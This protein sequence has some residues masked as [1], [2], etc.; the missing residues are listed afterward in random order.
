[1]R[2]LADFV[3]ARRASG[4]T[5][6]GNEL[7]YRGS[8]LSAHRL[9]AACPICAGQMPGTAGHLFFD[10]RGRRRGLVHP[11]CFDEFVEEGEF[12]L[13]AGPDDLLV[14]ELAGPGMID[15]DVGLQLHRFDANDRLVDSAWVSD[16]G[17]FRPL[18]EG[19]TGR[20]WRAAMR[21]WILVTGVILP[22][23]ELSS[24]PAR[25]AFATRR[26]TVL[27]ELVGKCR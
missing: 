4:C 24:Q 8:A 6:V 18:L 26:R 12:D 23:A 14:L 10:L 20:E 11:T 1:M 15:E 21:E 13:S 5:T 3:L 27:R 22:F 2:Q 19:M 9:V 7:T 25:R 17:R 16:P